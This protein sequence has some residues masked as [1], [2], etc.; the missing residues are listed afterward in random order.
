[1]GAA[2][3]EIPS[4]I[5]EST[6]ERVYRMANIAQSSRRQSFADRGMRAA[7]ARDP[8]L[9]KALEGGAEVLQRIQE[10]QHGRT[11]RDPGTPFGKRVDLTEFT[12]W[13]EA[14]KMVDEGTPIRAFEWVYGAAAV[15]A[16][17]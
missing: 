12:L 5:N 3:V 4:W 13:R 6:V 2:G 8:K 14:H 9:L 1:M 10:R 17:L 11:M 7:R 16:G 15:L